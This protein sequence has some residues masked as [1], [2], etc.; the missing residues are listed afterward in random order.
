MVQSKQNKKKNN[1]Q[2]PEYIDYEE[3]SES[4]QN[5]CG[6]F[7]LGVTLVLVGL[8]VFLNNVNLIQ[9]DLEWWKLWPITLILI[10]LSMLKRGSMVNTPVSLLLIL[11]TIFIMSWTFLGPQQQ[12]NSV[13]YQEKPLQQNVVKEKSVQPQTT[14]VNLFYYN[15]NLDTDITCGADF[16]LPLEREIAVTASPI[17]DTIN[18]LIQGN[19]TESEKEEGFKTEFPNKDLKLINANL[20][21]GTLTLNFTEVPGFTDGGVC[22]IRILTNEIIKTAK[23]FK[24]VENVIFEPEGLFQP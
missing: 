4:C 3:S 18:L 14:K 20:K 13:D 7:F 24:G 12:T 2:F 21:D 23:Q 10:G 16:V 17:K 5:N 22:R 8:I 1:F 6:L 19:L 15:K 9:I 11:I